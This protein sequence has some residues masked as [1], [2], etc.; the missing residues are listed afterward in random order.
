MNA[1]KIFN[2]QTKGAIEAGKDADFSIVD[3]KA[4]WRIDRSWLKSKCKW[5]PFD[6]M[7]LTGKPIMTILRGHPVMRDGEIK[8][9]AKGRP[10]KFN[11]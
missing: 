2:M 1:I 8:G 11:L 3:L 4:N 5:S 9:E 10:L 7:E 6:G